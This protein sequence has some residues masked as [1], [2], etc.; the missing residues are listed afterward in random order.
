MLADETDNLD[1]FSF[2]MNL[3][4]LIKMQMMDMYFQFEVQTSIRGVTAKVKIKAYLHRL[5]R[6]F[7][8]IFTQ[9]G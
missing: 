8:A 4:S 3:F 7:K 2:S 1:A 5:G 6:R 9:G